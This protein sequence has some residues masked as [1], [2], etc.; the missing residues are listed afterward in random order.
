MGKSLREYRS[1]PCRIYQECFDCG[2]HAL[3]QV[4]LGQLPFA[5]ENK[6]PS[7]V[8]ALAACLS[9]THSSKLAG[10]WRVEINNDINRPL[11]EEHGL[12]AATKERPIIYIDDVFLVLHHDSARDTSTFPDPRQQLQLAFLILL[13]AYT[14]SRPDA[15]VYVK[16]NAKV[17]TECALQ[18][19]EDGTRRGEK[20][21]RTNDSDEDDED[22]EDGEDEDGYDDGKNRNTVD[23]ADGEPLGTDE[24]ETLCYKHVTLVLLANPKGNIDLLAMEILKGINGIR[25]GRFIASMRLTI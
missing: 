24:V 21:D 17:L 20:S 8:H 16:K 11:T 1:R 14:A 12:D 6:H 13:C 15:L 10:G 4:E 9:G 2:H 25:N 22:E 7:Q 18:S 19:Y 5:K 3:C 23:D